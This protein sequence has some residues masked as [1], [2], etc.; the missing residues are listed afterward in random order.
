MSYGVGRFRATGGGYDSLFT[1][2]PIFCLLLVGGFGSVNSVTD[3]V[4]GGCPLRWTASHHLTQEDG[5]VSHGR[6]LG[7]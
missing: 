2:V 3:V 6:R 5:V 7:V 4:G 1:F